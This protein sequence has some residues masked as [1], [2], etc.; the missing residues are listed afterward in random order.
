M[1]SEG[2]TSAPA[3]AP[4]FLS[5]NTNAAKIT[6][7]ES[8]TFTAI[9]TDPD[10]VDDIVGGSLLTEDEAIDYGPMVAAGEGTFSISLSWGQIHQAVPIDFETG[11]EPRVF[12]ARFFDQMGNKA[13]KTVELSLY[14]AGGGACDGA[15]TDL[16]AD[17]ANCGACGRVC[18]AGVDGCVDGVCGPSWGSCIGYM[19]G[20]DTCDQACSSIQESCVENG[21]GTNNNQTVIY[22]SNTEDCPDGTVKGFLAQP[23]A[24]TQ[25][26][27]PSLMA[28]RCCCTDTQ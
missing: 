17:G 15:C 16:T 25:D 26:W 20:I 5:F 23:C 11:E 4:M 22:F 19:D 14:C 3:G 12:L 28:V 8:I 1:S 13:T 10:G 2:S 24:Q 27:S 21:C 6:D 7:G 9:L 18:D